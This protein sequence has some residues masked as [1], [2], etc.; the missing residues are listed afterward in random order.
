MADIAQVPTSLSAVVDALEDDHEFLTRGDVFTNDLI[1]T[2]VD[3]KRANEIAPVQL[4]PKEFEHYY[5]I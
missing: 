3:Y 5:K 1:E 4:R 2:W